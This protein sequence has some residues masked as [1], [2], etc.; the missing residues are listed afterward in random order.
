M[1]PGQ[2]GDDALPL[3]GGGAAGGGRATRL[4]TMDEGTIKTTTTKCR[5]YWCFICRVYRLE[6]QQVML[7]FS[8][9]CE[10]APPNFYLTS[11]PI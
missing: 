7:V 8:T 11:C 9:A 3:P 5:L 4:P 10:L 1:L 2:S 6:G